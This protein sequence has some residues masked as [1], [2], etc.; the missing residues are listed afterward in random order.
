MLVVISISVGTSGLG[1]PLLLCQDSQLSVTTPKELSNRT[2]GVR[3]HLTGPTV[4]DPHPARGRVRCHHVSRRREHSAKTA[5]GPGPPTGSRTPIYYPDPSPGREQTPRLE[6]SGAATCP[7]AQARARGHQV[8]SRR[9]A[10]LPHSMRETLSVL[11]H[12]RARGDFCQVVLL[13]AR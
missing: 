3:L 8:S 11:C 12:S 9:L 1:Y 10:H 5:G 6:G 7:Q 2:P 13:I 4:S